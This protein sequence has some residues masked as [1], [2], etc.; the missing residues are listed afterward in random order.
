MKIDKCCVKQC[1]TVKQ[2]IIYKNIT[3][4]DYPIIPLMNIHHEIIPESDV[5]LYNHCKNI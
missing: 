1:V 5:R 4:K 2:F 3:S